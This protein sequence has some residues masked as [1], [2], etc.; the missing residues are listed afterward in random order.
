MYRLGR[1]DYY[2][3][4]AKMI[5]RGVSTVSSIVEE[6]SQVL[7]YQ[8]WNECVAIHMPDCTENLTDNILDMEE[9]WNFPCFWA[10]I[11]GCHISLKYYTG[12]LRACKEYHNFKKYEFIRVDGHG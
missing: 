7:V 2:Y 8:L 5:R 12:G 11:D 1:G 9:L 6:V 4:I 10:A 3:T